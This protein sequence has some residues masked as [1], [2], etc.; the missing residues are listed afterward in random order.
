MPLGRQQQLCLAGVFNGLEV[1]RDAVCLQSI[2]DHAHQSGRSAFLFLSV[3]VEQALE[4]IAAIATPLFAC[5]LLDIGVDFLGPVVRKPE[6]LTDPFI[7]GGNPLTMA[8]NQ[9]V[10]FVDEI[11]LLV[12]EEMYGSGLELVYRTSK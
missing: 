6:I 2:F 12:R 3:A 4:R 5:F 1:R 9:A 8:P 10:E 7:L 11:F